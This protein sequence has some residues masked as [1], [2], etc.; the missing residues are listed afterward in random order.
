MFM[1][2]I[3]INKS[4]LESSSSLIDANQTSLELVKIEYKN[5]IRK[6]N[7]VIEQ[8]ENLLD[9]QLDQFN[10]NKELLLA[11]FNILLLQG[12]LIEEFNEYLPKI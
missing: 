3:T 11:Y 2:S 9:A 5:G 12:L 8:E 7:D 1:F 4:L 10:Y 6:F